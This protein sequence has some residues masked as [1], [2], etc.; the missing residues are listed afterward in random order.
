MSSSRFIVAPVSPAHLER[1][2]TF[3]MQKTVIMGH[4]MKTKWMFGTAAITTAKVAPPNVLE[5]CSKADEMQM[6]GHYTIKNS[7]FNCA[8]TVRIHAAERA[9]C[10]DCKFILKSDI[11]MKTDSYQS[12]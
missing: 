5:P 2:A 11:L 8:I 12:S 4:E 1:D 6:I 3:P 9:G 10:L 7:A